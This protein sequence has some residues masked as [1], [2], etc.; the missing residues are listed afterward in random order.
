MSGDDSVDTKEQTM[1]PTDSDESAPTPGEQARPSR[2]EAWSTIAAFLWGKFF[3]DAAFIL[4]KDGESGWAWW[5]ADGDTASYVSTRDR[6]GVLAVEWRGT[7]WTPREYL[8]PLLDPQMEPTAPKD[9]IPG[10]QEPTPTISQAVV[11]ADMFL[12][13]LHHWPGMAAAWNALDLEVQKRIRSHWEAMAQS[14][15]EDDWKLRPRIPDGDVKIDALGHTE[16]D[17][18]PGNTRHPREVAFDTLR[19]CAEG[20]PRDAAASALQMLC[21]LYGIW[22]GGQ[23]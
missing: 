23:R 13:D 10:E 19:A 16:D 4:V 5:L 12:T 1:S 8:R 6:Q 11:W 7:E 14:N 20:H 18:R 21:V 2:S 22:T 15:L 3:G 9:E 17:R